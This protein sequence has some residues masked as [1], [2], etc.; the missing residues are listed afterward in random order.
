MGRFQ[1][2]SP[3]N[4]QNSLW[5]AD[6]LSSQ[7]DRDPSERL[8]RKASRAAAEAGDLILACG[9]DQSVANTVA[10]DP[11][12]HRQQG[13]CTPRGAQ[14]NRQ[15]R[16]GRC[17]H[18]SGVRVRVLRAQGTGGEAAAYLRIGWRRWLHSRNTSR[19]SG[20]GWA[21]VESCRDRAKQVGTGASPARKRV[22]Q[23]AEVQPGCEFRWRGR[24]QSPRQQSSGGRSRTL[25][26]ALIPSLC[27][28]SHLH[29][30]LSRHRPMK[31]TTKTLNSGTRTFDLAVS[32]HHP[33][34]PYM[35]WRAICRWRSAQYC[36]R[37]APS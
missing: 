3:P 21:T 31:R 8:A 25:L 28:G 9:S 23:L 11:P 18:R 12:R 10:Q 36:A 16:R 37:L 17:T 29:R 1:T 26:N 14:T 22:R 30:R 2:L 20:P 24:S 32:S 19:G 13:R 6:A 34:R 33:P 7:N 35:F 15:S 4:P 5:S 27:P